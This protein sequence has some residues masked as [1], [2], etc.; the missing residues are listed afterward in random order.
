MAG[1]AE[2]GGFLRHA[3]CHVDRIALDA[4]HGFHGLGNAGAIGQE[5]RQDKIIDRQPGFLHEP[6]RPVGLAH[7]A[8]A[9]AAGDVIDMLADIGGQIFGLAIGH[10]AIPEN[11]GPG[12]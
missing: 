6:A 5:E 12:T 10:E 11:G 7:A 2:L 9:S 8:Q 4:G 3:H 1:D